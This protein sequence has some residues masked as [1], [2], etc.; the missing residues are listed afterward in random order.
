MKKTKKNRIVMATFGLLLT[1]I[2]AFLA[3][4]LTICIIEICING[5]QTPKVG[6]SILFLIWGVYVFIAAGPAL[7]LMVI[8]SIVRYSSLKLRMLFII[9]LAFIISSISVV[10]IITIGHVYI[11]SY[12]IAGIVCLLIVI[13]AELLLRK[14]FQRKIN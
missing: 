9:I 12:F 2:S 4:G 5:M 11:K 6:W 10:T 7:L 3:G 14:K 8:L 1:V 13:I